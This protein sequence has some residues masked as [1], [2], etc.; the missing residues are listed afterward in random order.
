MSKIGKKYKVVEDYYR[1]SLMDAIKGDV[2]ECIEEDDKET[3]YFKNLTKKRG[4]EKFSWHW[5]MLKEVKEKT[6]AVGRTYSEYTMS[7]EYTISPER[8][9]KIEKKFTNKPKQKTMCRIKNAF[10]S[11]EDKFIKEYDLGESKN[12]LNRDGLIE[13]LAYLYETTDKETKKSFLK[14]LMETEDK[15]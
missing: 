11:K 5:D 4:K 13:F 7:S 1:N 9:K 14:K 10:K 12:D 15:E 6:P 3:G 2:L 8:I